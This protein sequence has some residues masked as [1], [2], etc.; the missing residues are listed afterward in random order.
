M[1]RTEAVGTGQWGMMWER[2]VLAWLEA[3]DAQEQGAVPCQG[4]R[5]IQLESVGLERDA[6]ELPGVGTRPPG[7]PSTGRARASHAH[8]HTYRHVR[9]HVFMY[10]CVS[11]CVLRHLRQHVSTHSAHLNTHTHGGTH[12]YP[13]R[14]CHVPH[15]G[16]G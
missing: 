12:T 13:Y 5:G 8:T 3:L 14:W 15:G 2:E 9:A 16:D 11:Q 7:K 1:E 4:P 10:T 6:S